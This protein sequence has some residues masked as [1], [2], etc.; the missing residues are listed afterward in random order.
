MCV[1]ECCIP[2]QA[3]SGRYV[4]ILHEQEMELYHKK[5]NDILPSSSLCGKVRDNLD[6][7]TINISR[8]CQ[9]RGEVGIHTT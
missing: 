4:S 2:T 5:S 7:I 6:H 3:K 1:R 8:T 9:L